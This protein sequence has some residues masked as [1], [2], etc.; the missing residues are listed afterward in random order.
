VQRI[1]GPLVNGC[2]RACHSRS[3][4]ILTR[5]PALGRTR[6]RCLRIRRHRVQS[7]SW[8]LLPKYGDLIGREFISSRFRDSSV[9]TRMQLSRI[10]RLS[11]NRL[12]QRPRLLGSLA[13]LQYWVPGTQGAPTF[14]SRQP[15]SNR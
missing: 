9:P 15:D 8:P 7:R 2:F 14:W 6:H 12:P 13:G 11:R 3:V 5:T 1:P 10:P 4:T